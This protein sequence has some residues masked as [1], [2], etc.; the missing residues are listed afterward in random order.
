M[1]VM[2][3]CDKL[4][5]MLYYHGFYSPLKKEKDLAVGQAPW[6]PSRCSDDRVR[7]GLGFDER[8]ESVGNCIHV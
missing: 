2:T 1:R 5:I 8:R 4:V 6:V 7:A 3:V